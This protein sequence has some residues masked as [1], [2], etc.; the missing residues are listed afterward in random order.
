[1]RQMLL[2]YGVVFAIFLALDAVWLTNA[3]RLIYVPEIGSLLRDKPN[4]AVAFLFYA[5]FALGLLVFVVT[6]QLQAT[7]IGKVFLL[8]GFFGLVAYATYDFTNLAT[9]KGFT[10][11][12][13]LIDLAWGTVLSGSVS[14]ASVWAIRLLKI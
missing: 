2:Q 10:T 1:M 12:V 9:L 3:G 8:G 7:S 11:R 5:I 13:A 6:P 14:A 4:F